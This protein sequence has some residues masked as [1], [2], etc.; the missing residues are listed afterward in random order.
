MSNQSDGLLNGSTVYSIHR[1]IDIEF[2]SFIMI[3]IY[4]AVVCSFTSCL[5]ENRHVLTKI[6]IVRFKHHIKNGN[7]MDSLLLYNLWMLTPIHTSKLRI[8]DWGKFH[9]IN[10]SSHSQTSPS[11]SN[12]FYSVPI[13]FFYSSF[14]NSSSCSNSA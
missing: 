12:S 5:S 11:P 2:L 8:Q 3:Y 1:G 13:H 9:S 10:Y 7:W 6:F 4:I 14:F